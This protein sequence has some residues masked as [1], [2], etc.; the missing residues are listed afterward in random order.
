MAEK[1]VSN[2]Q[3]ISLLPVLSKVIEKVVHEQTTRFLNGNIIFYKYQPDFRSN[4]ST[5]LFPSFLYDK[6]F[7]GFDNGVYTGMILIDLPKVFDTINHKILFDKVLPTDL[8]KNTISLYK[9]YL[10]ERHFNVEV[11]NLVSKFANI[12]C[13]ALQNSILD[14]FLFLIYFNMIQAVLCKLQLY[15]DDLCQLFQHKDVTEIK[16]S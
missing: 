9:T 2:Y 10:A 4:H 12:S 15:A 3:P 6:I 11:A 14:P 7:K 5:E 16:N 13:G 1:L 8:L